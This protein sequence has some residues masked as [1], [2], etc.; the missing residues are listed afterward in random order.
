MLKGIEISMKKKNLSFDIFN[1][2]ILTMALLIFGCSVLFFFLAKSPERKHYLLFCINQ[3]GMMLV[4]LIS[5]Y[6]LKKKMKITLP[7][8]LQTS[9]ILF[10]FL[11]LI[12]GDIFDFYARYPHWDSILHTFSGILLAEF[13][14]YIVKQ[15]DEAVHIPFKADPIF[16][17]VIV[18]L[19]SLSIGA[20]WEIGEFLSDEFLG[21]NTQQYMASTKGSIV[22]SQDIP[23]VGHDALNDTMK[24]LI[25]DLLGAIL[26]SIQAYIVLKKEQVK[27]H[28]TK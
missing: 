4:A 21:T 8:T 2:M 27:K 14:F 12:L 19:V 23:L 1:G 22:G 20:L 17:C 15:I 5:P 3:S 18:V 28:L 25:L 24:D 10:C 16:I 6:I 9:F 26:V 7:K 13:G 11:G